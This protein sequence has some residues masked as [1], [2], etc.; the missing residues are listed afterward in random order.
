MGLNF[1]RIEKPSFCKTAP[2]SK[3]FIMVLISMMIKPNEFWAHP[4]G[5]S[6]GLR[7]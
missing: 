6:L 7:Y 1:L 5:Y 3:L 2:L 4:D